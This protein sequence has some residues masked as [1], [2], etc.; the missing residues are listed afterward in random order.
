MH[1]ILL[2]KIRK[3][4]SLGDQVSVKTGY[5]RNYLIPFGKAVPANPENL[6]IFE[7]R[8]RELEQNANDKKLA[9]KNRAIKLNELEVT[10]TASAG[11]EGKLFGSVG[12]NDIA[13]AL[14]NSGVEVLKSEVRLPNGTIRNTGEFDVSIQLSTEVQASVRVIVTSVE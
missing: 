6:V 10:I 11:S 14:T 9:A 8:K 13:N 7:K 5:G 12:S 1:L 4:G 2:E 3:L